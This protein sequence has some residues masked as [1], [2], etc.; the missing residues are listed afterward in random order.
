VQQA[1]S[2]GEGSAAAV[3]RYTLRGRFVCGFG[4]K[5]GDLCDSEDAVAK[6][7][8]WH[9]EARNGKR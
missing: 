2:G 6:G 5:C 7:A 1:L 3:S 4:V 8:D 9:S